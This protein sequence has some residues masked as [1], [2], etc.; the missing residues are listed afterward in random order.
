MEELKYEDRID[1]YLLN[2]LDSGS[3]KEFENELLTNEEL[4]E[5][6]KLQQL[7]FDEIQARAKVK[8]IIGKSE[9]IQ[10]RHIQFRRT[11]TIAWSAAAILIGV[12]FVNKTVVN[13]Q[14]DNIYGQY[15][16]FEE[17]NYRGEVDE[18]EAEFV[19]VVKL[20]DENPEQAQ[21]AL[22]KLYDIQD[23]KYSE[24]VRWYLGLTE[25]KLHN[26]AKAKSYFNEISN[27]EFYGEKVKEILDKL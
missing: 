19:K 25:L 12:F 7:I 14:M 21:I 17:S 11:M 4:L 22:K 3:R 6:F 2:K 8:Q 13:N 9:V 10:K 27:S 18:T 26:K 16:Q 23:F 15:Y 24:A 1:N 20:A 5:N